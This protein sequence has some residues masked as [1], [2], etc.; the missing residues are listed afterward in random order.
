MSR[1]NRQRKQSKTHGTS[2][3][4][5][6]RMPV[7][8]MLAG[9]VLVG[10]VVGLV[11]GYGWSPSPRG[12]EQYIGNQDGDLMPLST[13]GKSIRGWHDMANIPRN[14]YGRKLPVN[15]PQPDVVVKP[16]NRNL[17]FVGSRDVINLTYSV[18][19]RGDQDLIIG[20]MVTSCGCTTGELSH[21]IIPPGHRADL[22]VRFDVGFHKVERG[23][24]V[25]RVVWKQFI[26]SSAPA[27]PTAGPTSRKRL[28][29]R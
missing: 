8:F 15:Q 6:S 21:N 12:V 10:V 17:G 28:C 20:N 29:L 19:N 18:V 5:K 13:K 24:R 2:Q 16:A 22:K 25:V 26:F 4:S 9:V 14:V 23:E 7:K 3:K 1:K 27:V 11:F